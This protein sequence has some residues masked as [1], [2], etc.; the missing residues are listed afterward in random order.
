MDV[1]TAYLQ[2]ELNEEIYVRPPK[3]IVKDGQENEIWKL[4]KAM[5]GLKQSGRAWNQKLESVNEN[6]I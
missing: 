5:Y 1:T 3:E 2:G 6:K 4:R